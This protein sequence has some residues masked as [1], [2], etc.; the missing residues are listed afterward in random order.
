MISSL[1]DIAGQICFQE[2]WY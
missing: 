1:N 2:N